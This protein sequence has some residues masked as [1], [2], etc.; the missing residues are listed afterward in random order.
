MS[1]RGVEDIYP[2]RG[3]FYHYEGA[4]TLLRGGGVFTAQQTANSMMGGTILDVMPVADGDLP[5]GRPKRQD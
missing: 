2:K 3:Q 5:R 4:E 1:A